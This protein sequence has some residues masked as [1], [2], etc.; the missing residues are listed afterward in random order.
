MSLSTY[1]EFRNEG[2]NVSLYSPQLPARDVRLGSSFALLRT[3]RSRNRNAEVLLKEC[4]VQTS[5][6]MQSVKNKL[7]AMKEDKDKAKKVCAAHSV[8]FGVGRA[9]DLWGWPGP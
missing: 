2:N 3:C 5:D 4:G 8:C 7:V 1:Q 9:R 6:L